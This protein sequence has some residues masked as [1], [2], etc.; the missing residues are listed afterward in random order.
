[1]GKKLESL[2]ATL[3]PL[4][5]SWLRLSENPGL[6]PRKQTVQ[7]GHQFKDTHVRPAGSGL[8]SSKEGCL[9]SSFFFLLRNR[10]H[11][12]LINDIE[13]NHIRAI[14]SFLCQDQP[15]FHWWKTKRG[16]LT[17]KS[18]RGHRKTT[19]IAC[20]VYGLDGAVLASLS[21]THWRGTVRL[22]RE[23]YTML[24]SI[25]LYMTI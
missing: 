12:R 20:I 8:A 1:M 9:R 5:R 14:F 13:L 23:Q 21:S 16:W 4:D 15:L 2:E 7:P 24:A 22:V 17:C 25:Q 18:N 10:Y 11:Q 6:H 19:I 3:V